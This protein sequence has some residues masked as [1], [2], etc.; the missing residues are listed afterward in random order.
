MLF[1][2][3]LFQHNLNYASFPLLKFLTHEEGI[4][5][6]LFPGVLQIPFGNV[7]LDVF[8]WKFLQESQGVVRNLSKRV[9]FSIL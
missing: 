9:D 2:P 1:Y 6:F 4:I 3:T 8:I 7:H 5:I